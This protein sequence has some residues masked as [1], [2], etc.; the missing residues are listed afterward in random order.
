MNRQK[1][2]NEFKA[3]GGSEHCAKARGAIAPCSTWPPS[4]SI[5]V[6][7]RVSSG[8]TTTAQRNCGAATRRRGIPMSG[9]AGRS[10]CT[11]QTAVLCH[12][13]NVP[14]AMC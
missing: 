8:N 7:P 10:R 6:M 9:S 14:W 12:T 3:N 4:P 1:Q 13:S 11:A 2:M 5:P